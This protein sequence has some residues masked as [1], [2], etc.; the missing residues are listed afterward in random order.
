MSMLYST[1]KFVHV[2]AVVIW[3]GAM[4]TLAVLF[5]RLV[6]ERESGALQLL[7]RQSE[8][9]GRA[10]IGPAAIV[11]LLAGGAL[12]W[13]LGTGMAAWI[14]WGLIGFVV[15]VALGAGVMQRAGRQLSTVAANPNPDAATIDALQRRLRVLGIVNIVILLS[16]V[17]AM[18]AKPTL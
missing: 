13:E 1:L 7:A 4:I 2:I 18:V 6:R 11:T 9:V 16:V 8:F 15:S 17:W 10:L 14:W 3:L 12:V 5:A